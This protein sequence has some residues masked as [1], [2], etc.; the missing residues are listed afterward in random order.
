MKA[1]KA[2]LMFA[3][4]LGVIVVG[5]VSLW[6]GRGVKLA[7][8][9]FGPG[10]VGA[11]V[12]VGAVILTPWSGRGAIKDL[13][14]GNPPDFKGARALSVGSVEVNLKLSSLAGDTIVV[15]SV[16][17]RE[18]EIL[19]EMGSGGSNLARL[20]R[21][22]EGAMPK[23]GAAP[24]KGGPSKSLFIKDL[25]VSGGQVGLAAS[26]LGR[27]A[28]KIPLPAVHLSNLG[29]K[30][31][32]PAQAVSEVLAAVSGSAGKAVS[33]LG[34]KALNEAAS[35]VMGKLGGLLKGKK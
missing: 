18:P 16:V 35:T 4:V 33:G 34:A 12:S 28:V 15:D 27:E 19:Y 22:A 6:L 21:N 10:I 3:V 24:A 9:R 20:Q 1:L 17:V 5:A 23:D 2:A 14:I 25:L 8:E 32:S 7:V 29:G 30:G 13:V 31:R 26:A 11:P